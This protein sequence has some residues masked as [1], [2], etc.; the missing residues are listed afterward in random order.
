LKKT[1][2]HCHWPNQQEI[3]HH[4]LFRQFAGKQQ[5]TRLGLG[6]LFF[7]STH[8]KIG[9][10]INLIVYPFKWFFSFLPA[11]RESAHQYRISERSPLEQLI[12]FGNC[13]GNSSFKIESKT[14]IFIAFGRRIRFSFDQQKE[15]AIRMFN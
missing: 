11:H 10:T 14:G 12:G 9:G 13:A 8:S 4:H 6:H 15:F 7:Q 2:N 1:N 5:A 3:H